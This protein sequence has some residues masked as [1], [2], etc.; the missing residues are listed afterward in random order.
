MTAV[1]KFQLAFNRFARVQHLPYGE[2]K[3]DGIPGSATRTAAQEARYALGY[4]GSPAISSRI[5]TRLIA[6]L[7]HPYAVRW[8]PTKQQREVAKTRRDELRRGH[9]TVLYAGSGDHTEYPV[10]TWIVPLLEY[11]VHHG[12]RP[13]AVTSGYRTVSE[14]AYLYQRYVD[15]GYNPQYIAARPG[16]SEHNFVEFPHGAVD[17]R[18][19]TRDEFES[20]MRRYARENPGSERILIPFGNRPGGPGDRNHFSHSGH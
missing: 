14:Q 3:T 1:T 11:A 20:L 18:T 13:D 17:V 16:E 5:T 2:L 19:D 10:A 8:T 12:M 4:S 6:Q 15:S 9:G 7:Q